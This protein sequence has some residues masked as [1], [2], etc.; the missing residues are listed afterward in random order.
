MIRAR[1]S[2]GGGDLERLL[3]DGVRPA[4]SD[5]RLLERYLLDRDESAFEEL[6]ERHGPMVLS[7]CRRCLR[8]PRDVED[9]FQATFLVL[10]RKGSSLR[11]AGALSSWLYGVAY[12]VASRARAN[13][14]RRRSREGESEAI[15]EAPAPAAAP[16][17][18][19]VETLDAELNRLPE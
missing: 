4:L 10:V 7:L 17:D 18:D 2:R 6:V 5:S 14:L 1:R 8:D 15:Q 9:A 19:S 13:V 11:D 12:R 16:F 3:R